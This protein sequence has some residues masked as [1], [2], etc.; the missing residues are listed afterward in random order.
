MTD[1]KNARYGTTGFAELSRAGR[2]AIVCVLTALTFAIAT[3]TGMSF[4]HV[5]PENVLNR[6][7]ANTIDGY[8]YPEFRQNW[9]LFAPEPLHINREIHARARLRQPDGGAR[10]S[11]W[12]NV[13]EVDIDAVTSNPVPS[14][15]RNQLRKGWPTLADSLDD[16]NQPSTPAGEVIARYLQRIVVSRLSETL[17][18]SIEAVQLRSATTRVAEPAWSQRTSDA[19]TR[20]QELPWWPVTEHG[21]G[22]GATR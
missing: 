21:S 11:S 17:D 1:A 20:Y 15:T 2:V 10:T 9:K 18:G 7:Y 19:D 16:S 8:I 13:T 12:I 6:T 14:L 22:E 4:A 3:H 5:A